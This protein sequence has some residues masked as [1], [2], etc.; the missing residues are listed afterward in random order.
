MG[1]PEE[2]FP[3]PHP[4]PKLKGYGGSPARLPQSSSPKGHG[5]AHPSCGRV[6]WSPGIEIPPSIVRGRSARSH[7]PSFLPL[8]MDILNTY[9]H[10]H[11]TIVARLLGVFS[12]IKITSTAC[13]CPS[14]K[15]AKREHVSRL[16]QRCYRHATVCESISH[17]FKRKYFVTIWLS[18]LVSLDFNSVSLKHG[19]FPFA[20]SVQQ[21]TAYVGAADLCLQLP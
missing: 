10:H 2:S 12:N 1:I 20:H 19:I 9:H 11:P 6:K 16:M 7:L 15:S 18:T 17:R 8:Y 14:G 4:Q 5:P 3:H 13:S 21:S